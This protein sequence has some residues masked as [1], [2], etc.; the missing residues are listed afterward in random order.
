[1]VNKKGCNGMSYKVVSLEINSISYDVAIKEVINLSTSR[2]PSYVCF[3]NSHM[4]VEAALDEEYARNVNN[5]T[6]VLPD[7]IPVQKAVNF[8]YKV[9][10]ER[11][12]GMDF[13]PDLIE[14]A[15]IEGL[16][17]FIVGSSPAVIESV[18]K[19]LSIKYRNIKLVGFVLPPFNEKWDNAAYI[20][21]INSCKA[22]VVLVALGCPKQEKWM[23]KHSKDIN[24]VL[25]GIGGA[26]PVFAGVKKNAPHWMKKNGLEW[27]F[28]LSQ[29][30]KRLWRRY[31]MTNSL[32]I[33]YL[34]RQLLSEKQ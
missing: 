6:L 22:E 23:A 16:K 21:K 27:L 15:N 24:A 29:E 19:I 5:A 28:R 14:Q 4:T 34:I 13:L 11:I 33:Y 1:M 12:S 9:N 8:F 3:A 32:M 2:K 30:P 7:G 26:L 18:K 20:E 17:L 25:L 10:Q 31:L